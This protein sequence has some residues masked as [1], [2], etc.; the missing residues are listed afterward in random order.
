VCPRLPTTIRLSAP[1]TPRMAS[2]GK[3]VE[4][5]RQ[6]VRSA[7]NAGLSPDFIAEE[8]GMSINEV[9]DVLGMPCEGQCQYDWAI[10]LVNGPGTPEDGSALGAHS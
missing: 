5:V 7:Y 4:R 9:H 2:T 3:R 1:A 6:L 10:F 8:A